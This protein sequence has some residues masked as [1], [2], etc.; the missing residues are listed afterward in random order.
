MR[1]NTFF[2]PPQRTLPFARHEIWQSIPGEP[3]RQCRDLCEGLLRA[4]LRHE[5]AR[6]TEDNDAGE[7][8]RRPS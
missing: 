1:P 8:S 3:R 5:E 7:D 2:S 6:R 4:V